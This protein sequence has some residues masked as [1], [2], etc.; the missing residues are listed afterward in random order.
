MPSRN[1][2]ISRFPSLK[3]AGKKIGAPRRESPFTRARLN[4]NPPNRIGGFM[5]VRNVT[6]RLSIFAAVFLLAVGATAQS[7]PGC[8]Q[9]NQS[10]GPFYD[11]HNDPAQHVTGVHGSAFT[12]NGSCTYIGNPGQACAVTARAGEGNPGYSD[13]GL[14]NVLGYHVGIA[15]TQG[16]IA[17]G[18]GGQSATSHALG[19]VAFEH[20]LIASCGFQITI[21][22]SAPAGFNVSFPADAIWHDQFDYTAS[23]VGRTAPSVGSCPQQ[24][25]CGPSPVI[26]D[27]GATGFLYG[28]SNPQSD[29]VLFDIRGNGQ[30]LCLSWPK[31]DSGLAWLALPDKNGGVTTGKQLFG[32]LTPQPNHPNPNPNGF[33]ALAEYDMPA[34]GGN[35]D[36]VIDKQD[37]VWK[38]LRLWIDKHCRQDPTTA[39]TARP[40][41]LHHLEEFGIESISLVYSASPE[42]DQWHNQFKVFTHL[43]VAPN[44]LQESADSR[45]VYDVWLQQKQ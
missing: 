34:T 14:L 18:T 37:A 2:S 21:S 43:N 1:S 31:E 10:F 27:T 39:C 28:L 15:Q 16:G 25:G 6:N 19:A 5:S 24:S 35:Y 13:D 20:C 38:K 41:E 11:G 26:F 36:L 12:A 9:F 17:T 23:C 22:G 30:P 33:L 3:I 7:A 4:T 8:P 42:V 45:L 44:K 40:E 29:C 32:D